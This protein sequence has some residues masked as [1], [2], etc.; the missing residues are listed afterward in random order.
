[1]PQIYH[2]PYAYEWYNVA[3]YAA[4]QGNKLFLAGV[5]SSCTTTVCTIDDATAW[6]QTGQ[7]DWL[8][9]LQAWQALHDLLTAPTTP[10]QR[11]G[12]SL[13]LPNP[14]HQPNLA[15]ITDFINGANP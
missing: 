7:L 6:R 5:V 8:S 11:N 1:M 13:N 15:H 2:H 4:E 12:Q 9:P 10:E 14:I 3:R